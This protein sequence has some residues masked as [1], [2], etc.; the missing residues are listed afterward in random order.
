LEHFERIFVTVDIYNRFLFL[1]LY[2]AP[3]IY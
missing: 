3:L 2:F 1:L